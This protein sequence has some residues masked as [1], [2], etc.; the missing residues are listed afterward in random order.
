MKEGS[1]WE[2][3]DTSQDTK[4]NGWKNR[5]TWLVVLWLDN[6]ELAYESMR[7]IK[8]RTYQ[9]TFNLINDLLKRN[10]IKDKIELKNVNW[11]E[12]IKNVL[13]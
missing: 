5:D 8:E 3:E 12:V 4:Y 9:D 7:Q 1:S 10:L 6:E 2:R 13:Q 11:S